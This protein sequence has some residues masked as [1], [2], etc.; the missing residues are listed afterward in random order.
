MK[1]F[2]QFYQLYQVV[3]VILAM[4]ILGLEPAHA[5][6]PQYQE[7]RGS[8]GVQNEKNTNGFFP[9]ETVW[10]N[11]GAATTVFSKEPEKSDS[12]TV[13]FYQEQKPRP[14][15]APEI[16]KVGMQ[17][18]THDPLKPPPFDTRKASPDQLLAYYGNPNEETPL[19]PDEKA[20]VPFKA[21]M[22]AMDS[23][24]EKLAYQYA[25]QYIRYMR[26]MS[27]RVGQ[28]VQMQELAIEREGIR[29]GRVEGNPYAKLL[30]EDFA[31]EETKKELSFEG[32]DPKAQRM[33]RQAQADEALDPE[34]SL[35]AMNASSAEIKAKQDPKGE[36]DVYVFFDMTNTQSISR[37]REIQQLA[38]SFPQSMKVSF[39]ALSVRKLEPMQIIDLTDSKQITLPIRDGSKL[40]GAL[41]ISQ[42]PTVLFVTRN[43][44][45]VIR[46]DA[47]AGV[48]DM[49]QGLNSLMGS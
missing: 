49:K 31:S 33:L 22:A 4:T 38:E 21:M 43:S 35:G 1:Q 37:V 26:N 2:A 27:E 24:N 29:P 19:T 15:E 3:S 30:E 28:T 12:P 14:T 45:K 44:K 32:L 42:T 18:G 17:A 48:K 13:G 5:E 8:D 6:L 34:A 25:R 9:A 7:A 11:D 40:I 46:V 41:G 36:V 39:S 16:Q 10:F 23:G 20:P 47:Q